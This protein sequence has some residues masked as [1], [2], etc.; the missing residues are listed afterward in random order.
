MVVLGTG[1][2]HLHDRCAAQP[3]LLALLLLLLHR[4]KTSPRELEYW[5]FEFETFCAFFSISDGEGKEDIR[6]GT[7]SLSI[8]RC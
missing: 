7:E 1:S 2:C 5:S 3:F 4:V 8:I 6:Y